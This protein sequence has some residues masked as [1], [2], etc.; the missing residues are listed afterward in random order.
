MVH[1]WCINTDSTRSK[2]W[3]CDPV[4]DGFFGI[5]YPRRSAA[6]STTAGSSCPLLFSLQHTP[7]FFSGSP[8]PAFMLDLQQLLSSGRGA[9]QWGVGWME[10]LGPC[11]CTGDCS[12]KLPGTANYTFRCA[13]NLPSHPVFLVYTEWVLN[14]CSTS[15][16]F[17]ISRP[18]RVPGVHAY[19][20]ASVCV[21]V[22]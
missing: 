22:T 5:L 8:S 9:R 16:P 15:A 17:T 6:L 3:P 18:L 21:C 19:M 12:R 11:G 1:K 14:H 7:N 4:Q 13:I 20:W 2:S 10:V